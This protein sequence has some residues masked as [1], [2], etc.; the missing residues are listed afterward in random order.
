MIF[1]FVS[2]IAVGHIQAALNLKAVKSGVSTV[3]PGNG[4][5]RS[6]DRATEQPGAST[7]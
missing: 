7:G 4:A 3:S 2:S 1:L 5:A 6:V